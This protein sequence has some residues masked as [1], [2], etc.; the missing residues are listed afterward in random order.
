MSA[1][2]TGQEEH[3]GE[4]VPL[5]FRIAS[6]L[7]LYMADTTHQKVR[8]SGQGALVWVAGRT[9]CAQVTYVLEALYAEEACLLPASP[10]LMVNSESAVWQI[11]EQSSF[12]G[13]AR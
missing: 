7:G 3:A 1:G 6:S 5:K 10:P 13:R 2:P 9:R 11:A 12:M 4:A 8:C